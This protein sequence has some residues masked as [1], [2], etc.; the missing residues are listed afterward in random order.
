MKKQAGVVESVDPE[1]AGARAGIRPGDWLVGVDGEPVHDVLDLA[2]LEADGVGSVVVRRRGRDI[3]L[4]LDSG[5]PLGLTFDSSVFDGI[6][7]CKNA[8]AFCFVDQ[9]PPGLRESLYV[10]DDDYR[11][12]LLYGNFITLTNLLDSDVARIVEQRISP[13][14]V[15]WHASDP[16]VRRALFGI[17]RDT[18]PRRLEELL[19]A[20]IRLH[21]Q[22]VLCA[23]VNDGA[24][25]DQ[26][27]AD[28]FS[29]GKGVLSVGVVPAGRSA[30]GRAAGAP[31]PPT[32]DEARGLIAQVAGWQSRCQVSRDSRWV[33]AADEWYLLACEPLPPEAD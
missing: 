3:T 22:I 19:A 27:L 4:E 26:T 10:K 12:S 9:L 16:A 25:L 8:C 33:W 14:F 2:W 7:R 24:V 20:D 18:G 21:I 17:K 1:G 11:L 31:R 5:G 30:A 32:A 29:K 6:R 15:S 28:L 13:L 23:G